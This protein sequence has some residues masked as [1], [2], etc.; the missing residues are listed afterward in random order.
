MTL[1]GTLTEPEGPRPVPRRDPDQRLGRPGPRRDDL[2]AQAVPGAGRRADPPRGRRAPG[3]RPRRRRLD[4]EARR[5]ATS[6]DFAGDVLAGIAFLKTR[7]EIDA[8]THR[9]DGPQRGRDHRA[10]GRRPVA[11]RRLHRPAGRHRPARRGDPLPPGAGHPEGDGRRGEGPE[12]SS[13]SSRRGSSRS[14]RPRRT[15]RLLETKLR[16]V[17]KAVDRCAPGRPA[18]GAWATSRPSSRPSSRWSRLPWFRYFLTYDPRPTLAKVHCPVLALIGE[19]DRQVPPRENLVPDRVDA[20]GGRQQPGHGPGAA[21]PE[22]PVPDLQ[23][24]RPVRVRPDRGDHC[25]QRPG[26]DHRL[27]QRAGG[28]REVR[29]DLDKSRVRELI[30]QSLWNPRAMKSPT[31][32]LRMYGQIADKLIDLGEIVLVP[33]DTRTTLSLRM[34]NNVGDWMPHRDARRSGLAARA[35]SA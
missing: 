1:A 26:R 29:P 11:R 21:R 33:V 9:P 27:D 19:K 32:R 18:Q 30:D 8:Q 35:R 34:G 24:R 25:P 17:A 15:R 12:D 28:I 4:R 6:D 13:S 22:P 5:P 2:R 3:R 14:S 31:D 16:D 10:D 20:Q 23:D 7:A